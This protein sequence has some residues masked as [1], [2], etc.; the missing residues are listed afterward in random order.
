[1]RNLNGYLKKI[2]W[3]FSL[4][5]FLLLSPSNSH[6]VELFTT[7]SSFKHTLTQESVNTEL[8]LDINSKEARVISYFT[9]SIPIKNLAVK[10]YNY[11]T[12]KKIDCTTFE[13]GSSTE[14]LFNLNNAVVKPTAPLQVKV[15]Y[16]TPSSDSNS[17]QISSYVPDTKTVKVLVVYPKEKGKPIWSSDPI[18]DIKSTGSNYQIQINNPLYGTL[19]LLFG[20]NIIYQFDVHRVFTNSLTDQNQTFE[21]ILLPDTQ[22][23]SIIW[24]KIEPLPNTSQLDVNGNYIFKYIVTPDST[25]DATVKGYVYKRDTTES[26]S[27]PATFYTARIGYWNLT[28]SS[29]YKRINTFIT[30]KGLNLP[31]DVTS[32]NVLENSQKELLYK[33]LYQYTIQKLDYNR[34]LQ[35]GI[36]EQSRVGVNAL[37][38]NPS[39]SSPIDYADFLVA[40]YRGYD[41]PARMI[42]GYVSNISGFTSDGF[43]HYWVEYYD[44]TLKSW[45][46][47]DPYLEDYSKK[48]LYHSNFAD[49]LVIIRRGKSPLAPNLTFYEANDFLVTSVPNAQIVPQFK[50][51]AGLSFEKNL[52]TRQFTKGYISLSNTGNIAITGYEI[53]KSN[54]ENI[55]KY[56]DPINNMFSQIVLPKQNSN[57]QVNLPVQEE[58][59]NFF[60]NIKFTNQGV[61]SSEEVLEYDMSPTVPILL[62]IFVKILSTILFLLL[63]S[64][65]YFGIV[66][67][68]KHG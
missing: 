47:L 53:K 28:N 20:N 1:M 17:Y 9:A 13:R 63:S 15:T 29:E 14:I 56:I 54:I 6:A 33:Y 44:S 19:S 30:K 7:T 26:D 34:D 3:I 39:S 51:E 32:V 46:T 22:N 49:H 21:L 11:K 16:S 50:V 4:V 58:N 55:T 61:F 52:I 64:L 35:L 67:L 8:V 18:T 42:V 23:Q 43:F 45:I 60:V 24:E 62:D 38:D 40:L 36:T 48:S 37:V 59:I 27:L 5:L 57:I 10:C 68:R 65:I 12:S 41:I 66:K 2:P 31:E 25:I